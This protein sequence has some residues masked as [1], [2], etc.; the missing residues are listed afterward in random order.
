QGVQLTAK[1]H[2][3]LREGLR[4]EEKLLSRKYAAPYVGPFLVT[5]KD[6]KD[7]YTL[8]LPPPFAQIHPVFH[9]SLLQKYEEPGKGRKVSRPRSE[10]DD[11]FGAE[12]KQYLVLWL[13][14]DRS[15]ATWED[16]ENPVNARDTVTEYLDR[17]PDLLLTSNKRRVIA[18]GLRVSENVFIGEPGYI[19]LGALTALDATDDLLPNI[20]AMTTCGVTGLQ[21]QSAEDPA[22]VQN[23]C[24]HQA[25]LMALR[26][27]HDGRPMRLLVCEEEQEV[28]LQL[29]E[30]AA[31]RQDEF[32]SRNARLLHAKSQAQV[33][34]VAIDVHAGLENDEQHGFCQPP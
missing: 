8:A 13:G 15:E 7:N 21:A 20:M 11:V 10:N 33:I 25:A 12:K 30:Q 3:L 6:K 16:E 29:E 19:H 14:S 26:E 28:V 23:L 2:P 1:R 27:V 5:D 18:Q 24:H 4:H 31:G 17:N 9:V 34:G 32:A 22:Q